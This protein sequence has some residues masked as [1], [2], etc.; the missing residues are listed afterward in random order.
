MCTCWPARTFLMLVVL[1]VLSAPVVT[2]QFT[3]I[4]S[5]NISVGPNSAAILFLL[6]SAP[7][8]LSIVQGYSG[9]STVEVLTLPG[10]VGNVSLVAKAPVG[11]T[12]TLNTTTVSLPPSPATVIL[13]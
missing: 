10:Q 13:R 7:T 1:L 5:A 6:S 12:A 3:K 9:W 8:S 4:P 2:R 11:V